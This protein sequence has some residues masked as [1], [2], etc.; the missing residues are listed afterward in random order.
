MVA[1]GQIYN[2]YI[3]NNLHA[4][5]H[6][7]NV[8]LFLNT[9]S[10][11][12]WLLSIIQSWDFLQCIFQSVAWAA[13][14]NGICCYLAKKIGHLCIPTTIKGTGYYYLYNVIQ[15]TF[16]WSLFLLVTFIALRLFYRHYILSCDIVR[17]LTN[18][19]EGN[20]T[21]IVDNKMYDLIN[22]S[23]LKK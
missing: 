1:T 3:Q 19:V 20:K 15:R 13:F 6:K 12:L 22:V 23:L 21:Y 11:K 10:S 5:L 2:K 7:S 18:K 17:K 14:D 9:L 8:Y 4:V 16:H